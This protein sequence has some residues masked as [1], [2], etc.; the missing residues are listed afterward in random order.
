MKE[1][2]QQLT[3]EPTQQQLMQKY[4]YLG[5]LCVRIYRLYYFFNICLAF[6]AHIHWVFVFF[7][8]A[9]PEK[10]KIVMQICMYKIATLAH[11][12]DLHGCFICDR[13]NTVTRS[14]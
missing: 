4:Y 11:F 8:K 6:R 2:K 10:L 14:W 1:Q 13:Y 12:S 3:C 9:C 5:C 7:F